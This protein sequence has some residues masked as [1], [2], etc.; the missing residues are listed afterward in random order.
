MATSA[1]TD[2]TTVTH[3]CSTFTGAQLVQSFPLIT[4]GYLTGFL[5][6]T[7]PAP[8]RF[9][10]SLDGSLVSN[11]EAS[12]Y[13]Q[14]DKLLAFWLLSTISLYLLSFFTD[15]K[16][17]CDVWTTATGLFVAVAVTRAKLFHIRHDFH[18]IKK[19]ALSVKEYIAKIQNTCALL[20][21]PRS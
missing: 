6:G 17:V 7:L 9:V 12:S 1:S 20:D 2:F 8:P 4:E 5:E 11:T 21:A 10:Q 14:Q 15:A 13:F 3:N 16:M 19:G 18:S